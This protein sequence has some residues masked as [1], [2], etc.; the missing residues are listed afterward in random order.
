MARV[1]TAPPTSPQPHTTGPTSIGAAA[2]TNS[3][4]LPSCAPRRHP[5]AARPSRYRSNVVCMATV[6]C[7][8]SRLA[9]PTS[10]SP[11][12]RADRRLDQSHEL[13][14]GI[15]GLAPRSQAA[16]HL[17][18][19]EPQITTRSPWNRPRGA[20]HAR[21][22]S[23]PAMERASANERYSDRGTASCAPSSVAEDWAPMSAN[24]TMNEVVVTGS[25]TNDT[26]SDDAVFTPRPCE[27]A[28]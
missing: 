11:R 2:S 7:A 8:R 13:E 18:R 16:V 10:K 12:E 6:H 14:R 26:R 21:A 17:P 3:F 19:R 28:R 20:D 9:G 5:V 27:H 24:R 23:P 25:L 1:H 22:P 4:G 15:G